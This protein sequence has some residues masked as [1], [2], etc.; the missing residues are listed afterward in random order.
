[1]RHTRQAAMLLL[2]A[3]AAPLWAQPPQ[4]RWGPGF[5]PLREPRF[6]SA[7]QANFLANEDRV[8][9]VSGGGVAKAYPAPVLAWH[10]IVQDQLGDLP[11]AATW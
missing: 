7:A 9:G 11:I 3:L 5:Q 8:L 10:H 1:M 6:V 4:Q 2:T